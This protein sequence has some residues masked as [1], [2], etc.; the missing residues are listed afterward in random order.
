[1]TWP[2]LSDAKEAAICFWKYCLSFW[3][4]DWRLDDY[5]VRIRKNQPLELDLVG[6]FK[7]V[8]YEPYL[9]Q[10][11]KWWISGGGDSPQQAK[12]ALADAFNSTKAERLQR[13]KPLPRPGTSVPIEFAPHKRVNQDPDLKE[14]FVRRVIGL[15]W[16][17]ISDESSLWDFHTEETNDSMVTKI[18]DIYGV[19][20]SDIESGN[21]AQILERIASSRLR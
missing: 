12:A 9:A 10:V 18:M 4:H 13:G 15:E 19:D 16:A 11:M 5:P 6:R 17:W 14:E 21:V 8:K 2:T 20:I 3:K 7:E 1:M